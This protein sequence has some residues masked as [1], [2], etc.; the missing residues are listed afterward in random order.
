MA[1]LSVVFVNIYTS[2]NQ[3]TKN[4]HVPCHPI[5]SGAFS[6]ILHFVS[7][8]HCSFSAILRRLEVHLHL[9]FLRLAFIAVHVII[10]N[11]TN[12]RIFRVVATL[13]TCIATRHIS[14]WRNLSAKESVKRQ[15]LQKS[16]HTYQSEQESLSLVVPGAMSSIF[17][18]Q[19]SICAVVG[20]EIRTLNA[21][22]NREILSIVIIFSQ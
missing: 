8:L 9:P 5:F 12:L 15:I 3:L 20:H 6:L 17:P 21:R 22:R 1:H 18:T 2:W 10:S 11:K 14:L 19:L 13:R 16:F 7:L 4:P